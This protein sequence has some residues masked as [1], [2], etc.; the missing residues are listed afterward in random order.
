MKNVNNFTVTHC[1]FTKFS[2]HITAFLDGYTTTLIWKEIALAYFLLMFIMN[3][4]LITL[5]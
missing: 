3:I 1:T 4:F 2:S 5:L